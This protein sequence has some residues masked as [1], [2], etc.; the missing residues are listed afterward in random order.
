MKFA[1]K[2]NSAGISLLEAVFA[3]MIMSF[4]LVGFMFLFAEMTGS[5]VNDEFT[6]TGSHL[7]VEKIESLL[8]QKAGGG[9]ASVGLGDT[10]EEIDYES[11]RFHRKTEVNWVSA[12]DLKTVSATDTGFKRI[13]VTVSWNDGSPRQVKMMSLVSEY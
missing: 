8:A 9:Y 10:D 12:S 11:R 6:T 2:K 5:T 3:L 13:D 7:G 4:G 1:V